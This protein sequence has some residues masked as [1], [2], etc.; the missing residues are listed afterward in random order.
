MSPPFLL[1]A[2]RQPLPSVDRGLMTI[3]TDEPLSANEFHPR[4]THA[5]IC[6]AQPQEIGRAHV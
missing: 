2:V 3:E 5:Y 6:G 4:P 1:G